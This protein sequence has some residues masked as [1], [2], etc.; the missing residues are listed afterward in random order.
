M[1]SSPAY[2]PWEPAFG[3]SDTASK[4][5]IAHSIRSSPVHS[6]RYPSAWSPGTNG[7]SAANPGKVTGIISAVA[8]SFMV[9]EP[10]GIIERSRATSFAASR[11]R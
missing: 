11:R 4:P 8:L 6:S 5:V 3:W 7:C 9:H 10:S 2:S 1:Q